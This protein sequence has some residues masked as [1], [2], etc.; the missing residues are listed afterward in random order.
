MAH[1]PRARP[2]SVKAAKARIVFHTV[3]QAW[4]ERY[5]KSVRDGRAEALRARLA[6][7]LPNDAA[8]RKAYADLRE[9]CAFAIDPRTAER[10]LARLLDRYLGSGG[11]DTPIGPRF[12][13]VIARLSFEESV[14]K[15]SVGHASLPP[16]AAAF[17]HDG[18]ATLLREH[19]GLELRDVRVL[20]PWAGVG[21]I[22][23]TIGAR[24]T[25]ANE[26]DPVRYACATRRVGRGTVF[27]DSFRLPDRRPTPGFEFGGDE[28]IARV[29]D[30]QS[31]PFPVV[32]G[33]LR[34]ASRPDARALKRTKESWD[35]KAD[36]APIRWMAD[37]LSDKGV[38][39]F[40][41]DL[42]FIDEPTFAG[43][44]AGLEQEFCRVVHLTL[45]NGLGITFLVRAGGGVRVLYAEAATVPETFAA[46]GWRELHPTETHVWRT[47]ILRPE[48]TSFPPLA[49]AR[50]AIFAETDAGLAEGTDA[51]VPGPKARRVLRLPFAPAWRT[52]DRKARRGAP[53][54]EGPKI[55]LLAEPFGVL[56]ANAPIDRRMGGTGIAVLAVRGRAAA[57]AL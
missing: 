1:P 18:V 6:E 7:R 3:L 46:V 31:L 53:S 30:E 2:A 56:A 33:D 11:S 57:E 26:A 50:G 36:V 13:E 39:A 8:L 9:T 34:I 43:L 4:A 54:I 52:P 10:D 22:T 29:G 38:V 42:P 51:V 27:A 12:E 19:L 25:Y 45:P 40:V 49:A 17:I 24:E 28:N 15:A 16:G 14:R 20:D 55:V 5:I 41:S 21:E 32:V 47:E 23:A 48:W 37:R 44:R 35:E